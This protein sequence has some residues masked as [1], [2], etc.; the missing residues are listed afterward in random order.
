MLWRAR[1]KGSA[2]QRP[3]LMVIKLTHKN[4]NVMTI[5]ARR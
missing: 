2:G 4:K 1:T 5:Q 3:S